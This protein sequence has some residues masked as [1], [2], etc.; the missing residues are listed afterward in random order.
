MNTRELSKQIDEAM[1]SLGDDFIVNTSDDML[2]VLAMSRME[3]GVDMD[4]ETI[5][6]T[7]Y[8]Y[9]VGDSLYNEQMV[10]ANGGAEAV[11]MEFA[12]AN[13][14]DGFV[15]RFSVEYIGD[16]AEDLGKALVAIR[17]WWNGRR[18]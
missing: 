13:K 9:S 1:S 11:A 12:K 4:T 8:G 18:C 16:N 6:A 5:T 3:I 14:P 17:N 15:T 10:K 2:I 7:V